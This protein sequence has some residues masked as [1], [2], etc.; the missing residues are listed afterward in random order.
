MSSYVIRTNLLVSALAAIITVLIQ[1]TLFETTYLSTPLTGE[2]IV[3]MNTLTD[4]EMSSYAR[5]N[6][7]RATGLENLKGYFSSSEALFSLLKRRV[8]PIFFAVL[9]SLF[10]VGFWQDR[11]KTE[12]V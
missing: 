2:H 8:M 4:E 11:R 12:H 6:K 10:A 5:E 7:L 3:A 1:V 9:V